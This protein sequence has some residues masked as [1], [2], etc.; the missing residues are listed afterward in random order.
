MVDLEKKQDVNN[1][2]GN[3]AIKSVGR[4][5]PP[6]KPENKKRIFF[7]SGQ[8]NLNTASTLIVNA[9]MGLF[10]SA[11]YDVKNNTN[12]LFAVDTTI[13]STQFYFSV[14]MLSLILLIVNLG[15]LHS[16][17]MSIKGSDG[18][19][20]FEPQSFPKVDWIKIICVLLPSIFFATVQIRSVGGIDLFSGTLLVAILFMLIGFM[21]CA[22]LEYLFKQKR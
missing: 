11:Y 1:E 16:L 6:H 20:Y 14:G 13:S 22:R 7:F 3:N 12:R 10:V 21:Q 5:T 15:Y 18:Y 2:W 9:Y 17:I 4:T 19:K 8:M